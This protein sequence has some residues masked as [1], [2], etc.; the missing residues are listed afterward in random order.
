M[1]E[2]NLNN[3]VVPGSVTGLSPDSENNDLGNLPTHSPLIVGDISSPPNNNSDQNLVTGLTRR[4]FLLGRFQPSNGNNPQGGHDNPDPEVQGTIKDLKGL[5]GIWNNLGPLGRVITGATAAFTAA[6]VAEKRGIAEQIGPK[7]TR[8]GFLGVA[9]ALFT[10]AA[11]GCGTEPTT[12][13]NPKG[14]EGLA[15]SEDEI[16]ALA[17]LE[18]D[19]L[20][21]DELLALFTAWGIGGYMSYRTS[22]AVFDLAY[23]TPRQAFLRTMW[24]VANG[25]NSEN[26]DLRSD[27]KRL[28]AAP[29]NTKPSAHGYII[30]NEVLSPP[31]NFK[32][33]DFRNP[34]GTFP[35]SWAE[36]ELHLAEKAEVTD[37]FFGGN[38]IEYVNGEPIRGIDLSQGELRF[39]GE[40]RDNKLIAISH[41]GPDGVVRELTVKRS[42]IFP[43]FNKYGGYQ[44]ID[45]TSGLEVKIN[46]LEARHNIKYV[47]IDDLFRGLGNTSRAEYI[48]S[49]PRSRS[50]FQVGLKGSDGQLFDVILKYDDEA[51]RLI[52]TGQID[53]ALAILQTKHATQPI[54]E[55]MIV[56]AYQPYSRVL[57]QDRGV[58]GMIDRFRGTEDVAEGLNR[59]I[60][61]ILSLNPTTSKGA[62]TYVYETLESGEW[63]QMPKRGP[64]DIKLAAQ[65]G[66]YVRAHPRYGEKILNFTRKLQTM[67][68]MISPV[69]G[70]IGAALMSIIEQGAREAI[71]VNDVIQH[72]QPWEDFA[73]NFDGFRGAD[74]HQVGPDLYYT[75]MSIP[76]GISPDF[77]DPVTGQTQLE[78]NRVVPLPPIHGLPSD[79]LSQ[80]LPFLATAGV[81]PT[82]LNSW[83][84][85]FPAVTDPEVIQEMLEV[86]QNP[87][88][89]GISGKLMSYM[90]ACLNGPFL[91]ENSMQPE[92]G[93]LG[94]EVISNKFPF[95]VPTIPVP[96][97][98]HANLGIYRHPDGTLR[99]TVVNYAV[100]GG[101]TPGSD[102]LG[103]DVEVPITVCPIRDLV[104]LNGGD[105]EKTIREI[106][107]EEVERRHATF[108]IRYSIIN[109]NTVNIT[110]ERK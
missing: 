41:Q 4:G 73:A 97:G 53:D 50:P 44:L 24:S 13:T 56:T 48:V 103:I 102:D 75:Q 57:G 10:A 86:S 52:S 36:A 66:R 51:A 46:H 85:N 105:Y 23:E 9:L 100:D 61:G 99:F 107:P 64:W 14:P 15:T 59:K 31:S 76:L 72:F 98:E 33:W 78:V 65:L 16:D 17:L 80:T 62:E 55:G 58:Q 29:D 22:E 18:K 20:T 3:I 94:Q 67:R 90:Y 92:E 106:S 40:S 27:L 74:S 5:G 49:G 37:D 84:G 93:A 109:N 26:R 42:V 83:F 32:A 28:F 108:I 95:G 39:L 70:M 89:Q 101:M 77:I 60:R 71:N 38:T 68:P 12:D 79:P 1:L 47:E 43:N 25:G 91:A 2:Q 7:T 30:R 6:A 82:T 88:A 63:V 21:S 96:Y 81:K 34:D 45:P 35:S 87:F 19:T 11:V 104:H 69:V 110:V 54:G 8:R